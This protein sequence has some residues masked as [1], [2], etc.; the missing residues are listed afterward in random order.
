MKNAVFVKKRQVF[1]LNYKIVVFFYPKQSL[2][3]NFNQV[4]YQP[5]LWC[6][7]D[8]V[9]DKKKKIRIEI[10]KSIPHIGLVLDYGKTR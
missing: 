6:V 7:F 5:V 2:A 1:L 10:E 4:P 3:N 9:I 8:S